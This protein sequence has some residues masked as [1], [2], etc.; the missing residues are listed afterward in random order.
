MP[1]DLIP[2]HR[3]CSRITGRGFTL[4]EL[5]VVIAIIAL[6]MAILMPA[7]QRVKKQ[8]K[9]V[10][11]MSGLK[12]WGLIFNMYTDDND[13]K[14]YGAWSTSQQGH[15]WIG[16][17][18]PYY[19]DK[20]INFCPAATKPNMD[21]G[22]RGGAFEAYGVFPPDDVRFGY[23]NLAG[24][25]GIN[26]YVGDPSKARNPG[27]VIGDFS[28]YWVSPDVQGAHRIPLFLDS[29][30]LGGMP[31][32]TDAPPTLQN[33]TGG[34]GMMQR[35]CVDRHSGS[36]NAVMLDFTVRKVGLKEMWTL[37]WHR[38]FNTTDAWTK[39]GGAQPEDW[40]EWMKNFKDY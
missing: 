19:K 38:Q 16:A 17:L 12:Q 25:Y 27:G 18:R 11:C 31:H 36:I 22:Q 26:D 15:V 40:P 10:A 3:F 24:S 13:H 21:N 20:N 28:R 1:N 33:G 2:R 34:S 4:I 9:A 30:W 23:A 37:K 14:F 39:A 7:L 29:T 8:A 5:L 32:H 6:L 35:Y